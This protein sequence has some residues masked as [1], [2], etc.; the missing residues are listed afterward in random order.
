M[1]LRERRL[2]T[3]CLAGLAA[4]GANSLS[5]GTLHA[6]RAGGITS[7][8][9]TPC[10]TGA[11]ELRRIE[12]MPDTLRPPPSHAKEATAARRVPATARATTRRTV[13][14][15][16]PDACDR[17][18]AARERMLGRNQQGGTF[19]QRQAAHEAVADACY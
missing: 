13:A 18:R 6:C 3:G 9:S 2:L 14:R 1:A 4:L 19:D 17:A 7:Y 16:A 5:A 15:D 11:R 12:F 10:A 8:Q